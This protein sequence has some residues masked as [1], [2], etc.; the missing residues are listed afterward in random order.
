MNAR[1]LLPIGLAVTVL[2]AIAGAASHGRPLR[3]GIGTGPSATFFDY[4][5]TTLVLLA[6]GMVL[7]VAYAA[8]QNRVSGRRAPR[9]RWH[10]LNTI[11]MIAAAALLAYLISTS[12]FE[13]RL[14]NAI[15]RH[16]QPHAR[17]APAQK[18]PTAPKDVRNPRLR[19]D[20]IVVVL[21]LAGGIAAYVVATRKRRGELRPLIQRHRRELSRALDDS[22]DDLRRDPDIR[23]AIIA[24]Y[25]RM[26]GVLARA[27]LPR[28]PA[29]APF[30]YFARSLVD[31]EASADAARRLT[32]LFERAKFSHHEPAE[33]MR[34]EAIDALVAVREDVRA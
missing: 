28:R 30:E 5:A 19:W 29:E 12:N 24:A 8:A 27:G 20:E 3:P 22:I 2:L 11:F 16:P 1:R 17:P 23:R 9:G 14:Q 15:Q 33:S 26:E 21:L 34:D 7:L 13:R 6:I 18:A 10:L 4:V 31:L 32:A 25:A